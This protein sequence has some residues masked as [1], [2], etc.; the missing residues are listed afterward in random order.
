MPKFAIGQAVSR[1]EDATLLRGL[2]RYTDDI[3]LPNA[4]HAYVLRSPYAHA[5]I[6]SINPNAAK[7]AVGVLAVLTHADVAA[8]QLGDMPC[9][10]DLTNVDG[11]PRA[12]VPRPILANGFV[13]HV[14]DPVALVVAET[15]NQAKDAAELVEIDYEELP[16][17][18]NAVTATQDGAPLAWEHIPRNV[19]FD[20]EK[21]D[22]AKVEA[23]LKKAA[24][25]ARV[26]LWNNRCVVNSLEPRSALA[27]YD[28][29]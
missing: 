25:I 24:H 7:T 8:D 2:G 22:K 14:G 1:V 17:V 19:C 23:V 27:D 13:R 9:L 20:W 15:L 18:V 3:K 5:R 10:I 12:Q 11:S 16:P 21:G 6:A 26:E 28:S 4:A 29:G